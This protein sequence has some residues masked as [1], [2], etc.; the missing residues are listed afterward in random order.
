MSE[1]GLVVVSPEKE[2]AFLR[3]RKI[4]R[5]IIEVLFDK[6]DKYGYIIV[7]EVLR[8]ESFFEMK[9][10]EKYGSSG[11]SISAPSSSPS[12]ASR[13]AQLTQLAQPVQ[14]NAQLTIEGERPQT[15]RIYEF[16]LE[17][18]SKEGRVYEDDVLKYVYG[19]GSDELP[20]AEIRRFRR[21]FDNA[22]RRRLEEALGEEVDR[23]WDEKGRTMYVLGREYSPPPRITKSEVVEEVA[24]SLISKSDTFMLKD[25]VEKCTEEFQRRGLRVSPAEDDTIRRIWSDRVKKRVEKRLGV[26][27]EEEKWKNCKI[28]HVV[29]SKEGQGM[30]RA[31]T[32]EPQT[33][34]MT[35]SPLS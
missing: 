25:L 28:Y 12:S 18:L 35:G 2:V 19:K 21:L 13:P 14:P 15:E 27:L 17:K 26:V 4:P 30:M 6:V 5:S 34:A 8:D 22:V 29:R 9:L 1:E 3:P 24:L 33:G 31:Q 11:A 32:E 16:M 10:R 20:G 23:T 7:E